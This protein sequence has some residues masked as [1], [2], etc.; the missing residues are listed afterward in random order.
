FLFV[1]LLY[2]AI[3]TAYLTNIQTE[4]NLKNENIKK[5]NQSIET[6]NAEIEYQKSMK[7]M[8]SYAE[9]N[10]LVYPDE[11]KIITIDE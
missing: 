1:F 3:V 6:I 2:N 4:V 11:D 7:K 8:N 9:K 5:M 10:K